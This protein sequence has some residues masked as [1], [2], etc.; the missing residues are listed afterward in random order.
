MKLFGKSFFA[1]RA[2]ERRK[3][4]KRGIENEAPFPPAFPLMFPSAKC[5]LKCNLGSGSRRL[6]LQRK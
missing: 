5:V 2:V 4:V 3:E 1:G 6:R